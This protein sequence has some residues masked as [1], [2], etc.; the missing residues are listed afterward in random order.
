MAAFALTAPRL[1]AQS[2]A[3]TSVAGLNPTPQTYTWGWQ[4]TVGP[5]D[6]VV[7]HL[8]TWDQGGDGLA[9]QHDVGIW[10][11][12]GTL[13]GFTR[14]G[15]GTAHPLES[16]FRWKALDT[17]FILSANTTY[18]IG[19]D[20]VSPD[21]EEMHSERATLITMHPHITYGGRVTN[22]SDTFSYPHG[23]PNIDRVML[24]PNSKFQVIPEPSLIQLPLLLGFGGGAL[25]WRRRRV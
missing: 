14:I 15:S 4:F 8:G 3:I 12:G 16:G 18:R 10:A 6:I 25:W 7:T 13:I 5:A 19:D 17:P 1:D 2:P 24:G 22:A 23:T 21:A 9:A 11:L 20:P